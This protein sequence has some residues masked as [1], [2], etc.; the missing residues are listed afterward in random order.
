MTR[1]SLAALRRSVLM[2]APLALALTLPGCF[3]GG[4][5]NDDNVSVTPTPTPAPNSSLRVST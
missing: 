3:G 2:A 1:T 5:D 4:G